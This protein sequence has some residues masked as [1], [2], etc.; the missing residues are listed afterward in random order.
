MG[1]L[2]GVNDDTRRGLRL[3]VVLRVVVRS[4]LQ[5]LTEYT[6]AASEPRWL[7]KPRLDSSLLGT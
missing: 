3:R 2:P 1:N 6:N 5:P 4:S 7:E